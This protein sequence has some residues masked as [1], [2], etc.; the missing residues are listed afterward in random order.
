M[1]VTSGRS[2][3]CPCHA[4]PGEP[5]T[6]EGDHLARYL[7]AESAGAISRD[8]L[9]AVIAGLDV[10]AP[11]VVVRLATVTAPRAPRPGARPTVSDPPR[12]RVSARLYRD[13]RFGRVSVEDADFTELSP[14]PVPVALRADYA[15]AWQERSR[16]RSDFAGQ[17]LARAGRSSDG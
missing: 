6:P 15:A 11:Q 9:K 12:R 7:R 5:C 17:R 13:P 4:C 16:V 3:R 8:Y 1:K 14:R 10:L 2:V